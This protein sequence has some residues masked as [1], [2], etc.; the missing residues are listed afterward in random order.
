MQIEMTSIEA[1]VC[2][3]AHHSG[4]SL[5]TLEAPDIMTGTTISSRAAWIRVARGT[6][7]RLERATPI[8][9][10]EPISRADHDD[11]ARVR[12]CND[13]MPEVREAI[14]ASLRERI[15]SGTYFVG[16]E[17]IA[18]MILRRTLADRLR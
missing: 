7:A 15:E 12:R 3:T 14:V 9:P 17:T 11:V 1:T 5:G 10:Q 8:L 18:E 2:A 6:P 13:G 16:A 4:E